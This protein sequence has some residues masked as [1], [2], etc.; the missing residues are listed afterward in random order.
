MLQTAKLGRYG[1]HPLV[2]ARSE[3]VNAYTGSK[4]GILLALLIVKGRADPFGYNAS[5]AFLS[6]LS[7][8]ENPVPFGF[9]FFVAA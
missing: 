4:I 5:R 8:S 3:A 6:F 9:F 7:S 2:I 1:A